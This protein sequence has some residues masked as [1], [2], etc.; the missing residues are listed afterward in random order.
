MQVFAYEVDGFGK[1][2]GALNQISHV[3]ESRLRMHTISMCFYHLQRDYL[4]AGKS[5]HALSRVVKSRQGKRSRFQHACTRMY[6][7]VRE[8]THQIHPIKRGRNTR[9][10]HTLQVTLFSWMMPGFHR[11]YLCRY[12]ATCLTTTPSTWRHV[13]ASCHQIQT[14]TT[15]QELQDQA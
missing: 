12:L 2:S 8:C 6:A 4:H 9:Q 1:Q 10:T 11:S 5:I 7:N 15:T 3:Q 13:Q 14:R